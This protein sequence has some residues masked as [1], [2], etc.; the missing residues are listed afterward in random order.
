MPFETS[1]TEELLMYKKALRES[2]DALG[3][4]IYYLGP[5]SVT[6]VKDRL[7]GTKSITME[8]TPVPIKG[9]SV[10]FDPSQAILDKYMAGMQ[11]PTIQC[12]LTLSAEDLP[13][14][15][16]TVNGRFIIETTS[17]KR[18]EYRIAKIQEFGHVGNDFVYLVV[19]LTT[20]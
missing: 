10:V 6:I 15:I 20:K 17:R 7:G 16:D 12:L 13:P 11:F 14:N 5:P 3:A 9:G 18:Q 1:V 2:E 19:G 4:D 8:A